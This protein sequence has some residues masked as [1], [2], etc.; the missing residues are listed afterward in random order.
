[1]GTV[2]TRNWGGGGDLRTPEDLC[3]RWDIHRKTLGRWLKI[4]FIPGTREP[5]PYM[6]IGR[7]LRWSDEQ[8]RYIET[9]MC[10]TARRR[11]RAS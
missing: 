8:V 11:R 3:E 5:F 4:G 2:E 1:M 7:K 10:R 6:K 9:R